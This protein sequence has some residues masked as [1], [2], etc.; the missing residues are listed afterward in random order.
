MGGLGHARRHVLNVL[1]EVR[2][3]EV[4]LGGD[5][6]HRQS[7]RLDAPWEVAP[8]PSGS[9]LG[10]RRDDDLVKRGISNR[11]LYRLKRLGTTSDALDWSAG[12]ALQ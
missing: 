3:D 6:S 9:P 7:E 11:L 1:R 12:R 5:H 10:K 8:K 2:G 4:L